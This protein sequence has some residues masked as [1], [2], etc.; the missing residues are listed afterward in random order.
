MVLPQTFRHTIKP[1]QHRMTGLF[2]N[3]L[4]ELASSEFFH[5][6]L[7]HWSVLLIQKVFSLIPLPINSKNPLRKRLNLRVHKTKTLELVQ[8]N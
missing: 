4:L 7:A 6:K 1:G 2:W 5:S 3:Q 8:L